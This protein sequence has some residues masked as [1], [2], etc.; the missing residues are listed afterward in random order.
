MNEKFTVGKVP[1]ND[2]CDLCLLRSICSERCTEKIMFDRWK[3]KKVEG[4]T[5]RKRM[6]R[7]K[8]NVPR[9]G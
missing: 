2:P 3:W 7:R 6:K 1:F 5:A 8:I 9:N 4:I